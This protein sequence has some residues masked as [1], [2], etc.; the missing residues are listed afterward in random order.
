MRHG[1]ARW[2]RLLGGAI[3]LLA[4]FG[5]ASGSGSD[6]EAGFGRICAAQGL[7]PGSEAYITCVEGQRQQQQMDLER[8]R[9][10]REAAR[11]GTKL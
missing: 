4:L 8:I 6:S 7:T 10:A 3:A 9:Q 5:C 11:G 1:R 2:A